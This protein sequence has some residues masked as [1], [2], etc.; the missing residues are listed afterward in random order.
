MIWRC[1][2]NKS[3]KQNTRKRENLQRKQNKTVIDQEGIYL[4]RQIPTGLHS[5]VINQRVT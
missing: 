5:Y 3:L 4:T 1:I 2:N